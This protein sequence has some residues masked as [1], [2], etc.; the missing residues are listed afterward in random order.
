M[1]V[2]DWIQVVIEIVFNGAL[3]AIFGKWLDVK[4]K[5]NERRENAHFEIIESFFEELVKLNKAMITVNSII[6]LNKINNFD[7]IINLIRENILTQWIEVIS[8]YDTYVYDLDKFETCYKEM[9][10]AWSEFTKQTTPQML[11]TK[12]QQFKEA[13]QKLIAEVRKK[14]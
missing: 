1:E 14:Y 4:M 11:G 7:E 13:N 10:K 8:F 9:D 6:Q 2:E 3:L 12:L 5:R